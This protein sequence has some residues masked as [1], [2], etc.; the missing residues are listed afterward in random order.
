MIGGLTARHAIEVQR[1][2][3]VNDGRGNETYDWGNATSHTSAGWAIDVGETTEDTQN[4]DGV[5][6]AYTCRGPWDAD[7]RASD[8]VRLF[9]ETFEVTGGVLRQPGPSR[10]TSHVIVRLTNWTG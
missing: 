9:G 3:L 4:R 8:R 2:P 1:A 5:S 6:I 10:T 7:I